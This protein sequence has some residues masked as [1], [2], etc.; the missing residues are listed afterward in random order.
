MKVRILLDMSLVGSASHSRGAHYI[1]SS[2]TET[3]PHLLPSSQ[4]Q[5]ITPLQKSLRKQKLLPYLPTPQPNSAQQRAPSSALLPSKTIPLQGT[6][7]LSS[8]LVHPCRPGSLHQLPAEKERERV[9]RW[10]G[11]QEGAAGEGELTRPTSPSNC[12]LLLEYSDQPQQRKNFTGYFCFREKFGQ[13][14]LY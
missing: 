5:Q 8:P 12:S 13:K 6:S 14:S 10:R 1:P 3:I 2:L 4:V 11:G 9:R 7:Y